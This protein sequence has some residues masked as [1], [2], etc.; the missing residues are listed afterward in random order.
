[1]RIS[2]RRWK[3]TNY[4]ARILDRYVDSGVDGLV[5]TRGDNQSDESVQGSYNEEHFHAVRCYK[6]QS[7]RGITLVSFEAAR[8]GHLGFGLL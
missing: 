6:L 2:T 1:M 8:P 7:R 5:D 3:K 4:F